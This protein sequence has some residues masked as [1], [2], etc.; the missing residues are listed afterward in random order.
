MTDEQPAAPIVPHSREAEEAVTGAVLIN[1]EAYYDVAQFL[2]ADD[3][4]LHRLRWI[5][6]AFRQLN[7][8][9]VPIDLLTVSD[10]L[11][12]RDQLAEIGG[13]AY[14]TRLINQVPT[15]LNAEAYGRIVAAHATRR[16]MIQ[17]ANRI[18]TLAYD[19]SQEIEAVTE[20]AVKALEAV[21]VRAAGDT[22]LPL[23]V[24]LSEAYDR[25]DRS[26]RTTELPG[27]PSGIE[28]L[29]LLLGNFQPGDVYVF[30]ARPGQGKTALLL[31]VL[32]NAARQ[33]KRAAFFSLEM[34]R[35][36]VV[37]RLI[38][39]EAGLDS[40]LLNVGKI[41]EEQWPVFTKGL[42]RMNPYPI[43]VDDTPAITPLQV[44]TRCRRLNLRSGR[45]NLVAIDYLQLMKP[46]GRAENRTQEIGLISRAVK[47]L[48]KEL[49]VPVLV[50]AQLNREVEKRADKR[51][52]LSDLREGGD[53]E[54]DADA[55]V[56]LYQ[57]DANDKG[58]SPQIELIIAKQR[59]G[60][61]GTVSTRF[62]KNQT[63]FE[64]LPN[65]PG[66]TTNTLHGKPL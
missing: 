20:Q 56:F 60:P 33:G 12:R 49:N 47:T 59:N 65:P 3:F 21:A 63:R 42:E 11:E 58:N 26:S 39:Q 9:R 48:A 18:A 16:R 57:P 28:D 41:G 17:A 15:S 24:S 34:S 40:Q 55:V 44:L 45:L 14:L 38:S 27:V 31:S 19:E 37:N 23:S 4:Y 7:E 66:K 13:P 10:E 1:P 52:Q 54:A 25:V 22:L 30:A 2:S 46:G 61:V 50:A 6:E 8:R 36:K 62:I 5:W 51:P 35:E 29:D 43:Y 53:I 64:S 32:L